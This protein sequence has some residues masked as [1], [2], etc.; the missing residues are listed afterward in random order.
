M[1]AHFKL[2]NVWSVAIFF[3][4]SEIESS[5]LK[6]LTCLWD[7]KQAG[8]IQLKLNGQPLP[9]SYVFFLYSSKGNRSRPL[10]FTTL[11]ILFKI[12]FL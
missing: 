6:E 8:N 10:P 11:I 12:I 7:S 9:R 3:L 1:R 2:V 5:L 4:M